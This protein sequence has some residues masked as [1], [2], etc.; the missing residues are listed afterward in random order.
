M[1][2]KD[3]KNQLH[4]SEA[5]G[6]VLRLSPEGTNTGKNLFWSIKILVRF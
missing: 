4:Y 3:Q 2:T 1:I 5:Q 6:D